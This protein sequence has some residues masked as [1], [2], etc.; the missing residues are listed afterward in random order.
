MCGRNVRNPVLVKAR[1]TEDEI[2]ESPANSKVEE[3]R[4]KRSTRPLPG[5]RR[6]GYRWNLPR[7]R[8][9]GIALAFECLGF[10]RVVDHHVGDRSGWPMT[11]VGGC[12]PS[13][14]N[15]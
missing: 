13:G 3:G 15:R 14:R 6:R 1:L 7:G 9:G 11:N 5:R 4:G 12:A 2:G 10:P 8:W